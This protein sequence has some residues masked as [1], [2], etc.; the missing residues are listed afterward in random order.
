MAISTIYAKMYLTDLG[1]IMEKKKTSL[2]SR[3]INAYNQIES[4]LRA[5]CDLKASISYT[6]AVHRAA[7]TNSIVSKFEDVLVDYGRLR[8]AIVHSSSD[9]YVIAEPYPEV[10]E[11]YEHIASMICTP[12]LAIDTVVVK[13]VRCTDAV[14]K[15]RDVLSFMYKSGF[16][17]LP[18]YRD[19]MIIG[20][21]NASKI[22][23][24]IGQ[25][26]YEKVDINEYLETPIEEVVKEYAQ[27]GFYTVVKEDV[28][29]DTVLNLFNENRKLLLV[30]LT[31]GGSLLEAPIGIITMSDL[32]DINKVLENYN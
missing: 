20:V 13:D 19:G 29:L 1:E 28:A 11:Q 27:D 5:Q 22:A 8:N 6:E 4:A 32:L 30:I 25:K 7:R 21:A 18:V 15:L 14:V 23:R 3:F 9:E 26:V 24:V 2:A 16:S 17:N 10:V 12:P 31:K